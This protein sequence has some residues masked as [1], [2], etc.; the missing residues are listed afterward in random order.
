MVNNTFIYEM[1]KN[2]SLKMVRQRSNGTFLA[3]FFINVFFGFLLSMVII[4]TLFDFINAKS[5]I[6]DVM[7]QQK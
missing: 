4:V 7:L 6:L 5:T 3:I 2:Y 1:Q